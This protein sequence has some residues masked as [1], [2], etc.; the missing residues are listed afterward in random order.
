MKR[1]LFLLLMSCGAGPDDLF[2]VGGRTLTRAGEGQP[3]VP[4]SVTRV[5][6]CRD[7]AATRLR[8][9]ASGDGGEFSFDFVRVEVQS[10]SDETP[11][12]TRVEAAYPG[13]ARVWSRLS[14]LPYRLQLPDFT[15]WQANLTLDGGV[16]QLTR[17]VDEQTLT[18]CRG[19]FPEREVVEHGV[20]VRTST[21]LAWE[22]TDH[23]LKNV[24]RDGGFT[25]Q[26][27][28]EPVPLELP[29]EA[30][31]DFDVEVTAEAKRIGCVDVAGGGNLG[32]P[33]PFQVNTRWASPGTLKL[34]GTEPAASRGGRCDDL[35]EPC[36]LT[37]GSLEPVLFAEPTNRFT[38]RFD[39]PVSVRA[40]AFR[41]GLTDYTLRAEELSVRAGSDATT[42]RPDGGEPD[43]LDDLAYVPNGELAR[44]SYRLFVLDRRLLPAT[45]IELETTRTF[46]GLAEISLFE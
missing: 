23:V 28:Y 4:L 31:E 38:L 43:S 12:C 15:D 36:P 14:F 44:R 9:S 17:A 24:V 6:G 8:E 29:P 39:R 13:G 45:V 30:L 32:L 18:E 25:V 19:T 42:V 46:F 7:E 37:D 35:P 11:I 16:P 20:T 40:V 26:T 1:A 10:L 2:V 22:A 27:V 34:R 41:G 21:G 3:D 33:G 5:R